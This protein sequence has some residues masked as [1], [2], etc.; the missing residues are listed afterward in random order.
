[1][2]NQVPQSSRLLKK[3]APPPVFELGVLDH[4]WLKNQPPERL[5]YS[6][7]ATRD[8]GKVHAIDAWVKWLG[9][10]HYRPITEDY[11][12]SAEVSR[13]V[14]EDAVKDFR[15]LFSSGLVDSLTGM[16]FR[17]SID[18]LITSGLMRENALMPRAISQ[19]DDLMIRQIASDI[20][21]SSREILGEI[22]QAYQLQIA[23]N[24]TQKSAG[25]NDRARSLIGAVNE[26]N[27][28]YMANYLSPESGVIV[29]PASADEDYS[30]GKDA[31]C[32]V[33]THRENIRRFPI[34]L[35]SSLSDENPEDRYA[36]I[37][38][39]YTRSL[40]GSVND[41]ARRILQESPDK[42][43]EQKLI[44]TSRLVQRNL[45]GLSPRGTTWPTN[46]PISVV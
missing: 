39:I 37:Q 33:A 20:R 28:L 11:L 27:Y 36:D 23:K 29:L 12:H 16:D 4:G 34:Q 2:H 13:E 5:P 17:Y 9:D 30:G 7:L 31:W 40:Y 6:S 35:K 26:I 14:Y 24:D 18:R 46:Q 41:T 15:E 45:R 44:N 1:M 25:D 22:Y 42:D 8:L 19:G 38:V 32:Y 43:D 3:I 10:S 21:S